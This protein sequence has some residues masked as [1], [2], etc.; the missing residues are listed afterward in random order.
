MPLRRR[1]KPAFYESSCALLILARLGQ[2]RAF[3]ASGNSSL[4]S[5]LMQR[6]RVLFVTLDFG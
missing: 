6:R 1:L 2:H 5:C 3:H 4:V